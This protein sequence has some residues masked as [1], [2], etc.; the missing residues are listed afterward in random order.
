MKKNIT[1]IVF[2]A[3]ITTIKAQVSSLSNLAS[4]ELKTFT[5]IPELDGSIYGY[6]SIY[7]LENVSETEEKFEYFLLDKNLNKVANGEFIDIKYKKFESKF[8]YPEK[9]KNKLIISKAYFYSGSAT[10]FRRSPEEYTFVSHRF[11]DIE[12]NKVSEPFYYKNNEIIK[13]TRPVK[14]IIKT[15]KKEKTIDFP[16]VYNDGFFMFERI[17]GSSNDLKEMKSL[18]AFDIDKKLKWEYEYNPSN[19]KIIYDFRVLNNKA[20]IF[21]TFN[22]KTKVIKLH[23]LDPKTG[24]PNF[25]YELENRSS[26]YSH[27]YKIETVND[28][29]VIIGKMSPYKSYTGYDYEKSLGF[30]KIELDKLGNEISKNYFKW[31]DAVNYIDIKKNG[32]LKKGYKLASRQYFVFKNGTIS[33]LTEKVKKVKR[34]DFVILNF[35]KDFKLTSTETIE[36]P[37]NIYNSSYLFSQKVEDGNGVAFFYKYT[38]KAKKEFKFIRVMAIGTGITTLNATLGIV[39]IINGKINKEEIPMSSKEYT[40]SPYIAKEGYI[41]FRE[42]NKNSN[43]DEIRLEKLNY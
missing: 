11:F 5:A 17:K 4:G 36:K 43:Y 27:N 21:R 38:K 1:L 23:S 30:F 10:V 18:K 25:V 7:K 31:E 39:T 16:L 32:K 3:L 29:I 24:N 41:L 6:F 28:K 35:D 22:K 2:I 15:A 20:I 33:I 12:N 8:Y 19:E 34:T 9:I 42:F 26:E 13:G 40:I 37:K 14:K